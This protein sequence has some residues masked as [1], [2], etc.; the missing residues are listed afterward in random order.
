MN[1]LIACLLTP[2]PILI[3]NTPERHVQTIINEYFEKLTNNKNR[4]NSIMDVAV[5]LI[6]AGYPE[7]AEL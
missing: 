6:D 5:G 1:N 2:A 4:R 7:A 3:L